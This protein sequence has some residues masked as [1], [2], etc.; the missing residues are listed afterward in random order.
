MSRQKLREDIQLPAFTPVKATDISRNES[1]QRGLVKLQGIYIAAQ[2][3]QSPR[4][5]N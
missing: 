5:T 4:L 2:Q 3:P 1:E